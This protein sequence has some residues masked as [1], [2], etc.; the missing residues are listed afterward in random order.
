MEHTQQ[1]NILD[2]LIRNI[3]GLFDLYI[4]DP[5]F[6]KSNVNTVSLCI[7]DSNNV[8]SN[9]LEDYDYKV[10]NNG[11]TLYYGK[12]KLNTHLFSYNNIPFSK[13]FN[14]KLYLCVF[15]LNKDIV[16]QI[17][18]YQ[19][20]FRW[21]EYF[22]IANNNNDFFEMDWK[23][24]IHDE[25]SKEQPNKLRILGGLAGTTVNN[26]YFSKNFIESNMCIY[27]SDE[28]NRY[29][30]VNLTHIR[31]NSNTTD[32]YNSELDVYSYEKLLSFT[33]MEAGKCKGGYPNNYDD[34]G[35]NLYK[36]KIFDIVSE[37]YKIPIQK[38]IKL[39]NNFQYKSVNN[40]NLN[41]D[42]VSN[43]YL[44]CNNSKYHVEKIILKL[45]SYEFI[46]NNY[47]YNFDTFDLEF[48]PNDFGYKV[49]GLSDFL[50]IPTIGT[51]IIILE[52]TFSTQE[53]IYNSNDLD[54]L[55]PIDFWIKLD[56]YCLNVDSRRNL[57]R[58]K[59]DYSEYPIVDLVDYTLE[60]KSF[61]PIQ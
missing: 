57:A 10:Y 13:M 8:E 60:V 6:A 28:T 2:C 23:F 44:L 31:N 45:E 34:Y 35:N 4:Y 51:F 11:S 46:N 54:K 38:I 59:A 30:I 16:E 56:R 17:I 58:S 7:K 52:I 12:L 48:V 37:T 29:Q 36:N 20:E 24:N 32:F 1:I 41:I 43:I 3:T 55:F 40:F 42:A 19:I 50:I 61:T 25:L 33:V 14:N 49:S 53:E 26:E 21:T 47:I 27:S 39:D 5:E 22:Q 9:I 18:N 15:N